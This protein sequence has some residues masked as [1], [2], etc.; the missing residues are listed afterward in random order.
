M[1]TF[2]RR[3]AAVVEIAHRQPFGPPPAGHSHFVGFLE[4]PPGAAAVRATTA[5]SN[6]H[7]RFEVH[8]AE[9]HWLI[10]GGMSDTS[11]KP[12]LLARAVGVP[13]TTRNTTSLRKL[14][15]TL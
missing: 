8:G 2:V 10:A 15:A 11:V 4:R 12:A 3:A 1:P 13:F 6:G 9:L 7:D 5:L 14:A